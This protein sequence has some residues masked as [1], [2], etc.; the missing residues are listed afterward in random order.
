MVNSIT[1][2]SDSIQV[3]YDNYLN[4]RYIVNRMYQRKLVWTQEEK[5]AF[6]DSI[7]NNY[8]V[9]LFLLAQNSLPDGGM[10]YEIIDGMQRLNAIVAFI[11]NEYPIEYNGRSCYFSLDTLASTLNKLQEHQLVQKTPIMPKDICLKIVSY[12]I[13]FSYIVADKSSVEEIFRRINSFGKQLSGQEIRQAGATGVFSDLVRRIATTIRGDVSNGDKLPLNK[14][15]EISLS[16]VKLPYG[17]DVNEIWWIKQHIITPTNIRVSRDEE[18]IAWLVAYIV[19]GKDASPSSKALNR[20]YRFDVFDQAGGTQAVKI[21]NKIT[22][23]GQENVIKMFCGSFSLLLDILHQA[24]KDF[25]GL[26]YPSET[27]AEGLVRTFQI[28]FLSLYE[29]RYVDHKGIANYSKVIECLGDCRKTS[30]SKIREEEWNA[31]TRYNRILSLKGLLE[32]YFKQCR[33]EDVAKDNW[34]LQIDNIMRL[35]TIE[36]AQYDFKMGF[37]D[38]S[39]GNRNEKLQ[40]KCIKFLTAASNKG[41]HTHSYLIVGVTEGKQSFED[42]KKFYGTTKGSKYENTNFY[43]TGID[44][45]VKRFYGGAVDKFQNEILSII[46]SSPV[47]DEI[48]HYI[49]TNIKFPRYYDTTIMMLE[50]VSD[51]PVTYDDKYFERQGNNIVEVTGIKG[52]KALESRFK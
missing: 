23:L 30:L 14:M 22:Q 13:P 5:K 6:I 17:I 12:Q 7:L 48:K 27:E 50:L 43:I 38:L 51:A 3:V 29:L 20:L 24:N 32:P 45:E 21:E 40:K 42:F 46:N 1:S 33:G 37:H 39:T 28:V 10:E 26:I 47:E 35:S 8:S 15:K 25:C 52:I 11:E 16:N 19:L 18:L 2:K 41:K 44:E 4:N 49:S 9:P 34:S 36:G 31:N